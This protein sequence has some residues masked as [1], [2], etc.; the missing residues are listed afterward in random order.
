M[1]GIWPALVGTDS[2]EP[3][4]P[5]VCLIHPNAENRRGKGKKEKEKEVGGGELRQ[6]SD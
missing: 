6:M 2:M 1:E 3:V 4:S 5:Y